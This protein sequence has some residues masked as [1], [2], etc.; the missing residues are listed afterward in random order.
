MSNIVSED[1]PWTWLMF[2]PVLAIIENS[3]KK[4]KKNNNKNQSYQSK[5]R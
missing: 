5:N 1:I 2:W 4:N 3:K